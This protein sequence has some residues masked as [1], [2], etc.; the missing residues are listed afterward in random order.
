[1]LTKRSLSVVTNIFYKRNI[2]ETRTE[3][4]IQRN[5]RCAVDRFQWLSRYILIQQKISNQPVLKLRIPVLSYNY[6]TSNGKQLLV[7][8]RSFVTSR[9]AWLSNLHNTHENTQKHFP[10]ISVNDSAKIVECFWNWC[11]HKQLKQA[12]WWWLNSDRGLS[13][14]YS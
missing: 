1:M 11:K 6:K 8:L 9:I 7:N 12:Q 10:L 2:S 5:K 14:D 13:A 4:T 3:N